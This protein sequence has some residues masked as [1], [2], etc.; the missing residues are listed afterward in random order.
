MDLGRVLPLPAPGTPLSA[1]LA[2]R[3]RHADE[4]HRL[5]RAVHRLLGELRRDYAHPAEVLGELEREL[6]AA[7]ADYRAAGTAL[8]LA[9]RTRLI[10]VAVALTGA[11]GAAA[12]LP[13]WATVT[14]ATAGAYAVNVATAPIRPLKTRRD[15]HDFAYLHHVREDLG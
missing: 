3:E 14:A 8:R 1:V 2:F 6:S 11:A 10:T 15:D 5:L 12:S 9:W 4:R 13:G 7:A